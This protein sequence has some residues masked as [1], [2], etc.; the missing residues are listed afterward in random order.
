[1]ELLLIV[2]LLFVVGALN[3]ACFFIGAKVGQTATRGE[4]IKLP[5]VNPSAARKERRDREAA[6]DEQNRVNTILENI[7]NYDG[8]GAYQKE[9]PRR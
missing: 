6:E 5:K 4:D 7:E 9:V 2:L 3:V 1:M 8:T